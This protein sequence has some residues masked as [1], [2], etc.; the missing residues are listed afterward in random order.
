MSE[1]RKENMNKT[2]KKECDRK[3]LDNRIQ[4]SILNLLFGDFSLL[5][6]NKV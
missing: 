1:S 4:L 5:K 3:T 6:H 2:K